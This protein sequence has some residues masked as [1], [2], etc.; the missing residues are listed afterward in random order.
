MD[1]RAESPSTSP[2]AAP[3]TQPATPARDEAVT[4]SEPY[5]EPASAPTANV[6]PTAANSNAAP[7]PTK[8]A[9]PPV[10]SAAP[11]V[12]TNLDS[13]PSKVPA[14]LPRSGEAAEPPPP[15]AARKAA[16]I[17]K[18]ESIRR[19][20]PDY[21]T[22]ARAARQSGMVAVEVSINERGEVAAAQALSGPVLLRDAAVAAAR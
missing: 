10:V 20:Q 3:A 17:V 4:S 13:P 2:A 16:V 1:V 15:V 19:V 9:A 12:A 5:K 6:N 14:V 8:P 22:S 11:Q 7:T 18:G 21:P